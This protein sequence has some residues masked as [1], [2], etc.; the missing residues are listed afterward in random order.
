MWVSSRVRYFLTGQGRKSY[1][2]VLDVIL[3]PQFR[4]S[5]ENDHV[6]FSWLP[7]DHCRLGSH[8][9][10]IQLPQELVAFDFGLL[11]AAA[12]LAPAWANHNETVGL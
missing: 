9:R 11:L 3:A 1:R 6:E 10:T 4:Q 12:S 2:G 5:A 7:R 8:R